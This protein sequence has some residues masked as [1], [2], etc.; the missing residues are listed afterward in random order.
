[1]KHLL[2]FLAIALA[3]VAFAN[4][5]WSANIKAADVGD[6]INEGESCIA[7]DGNYVYC[8]SNCAERASYGVIP[9]GRSTDGGATWTTTWWHDPT[10]PNQW[11][12][13][14]VIIRD[15]TGYVHLFVQYSTTVIRHY[16]STDH[17]VS[18]A[19]T[20]D[21]S[22]MTG[23]T[24]DKCWFCCHGNNIYGCWQE[25]GGAVDG[26]RFTKS[27]DGGLTWNTIVADDQDTGMSYVTTSPSG[28]V[29]LMNRNWGGSSVLCT[30]STDE[31]ET[32]APWVEIDDN[33]TYSS[34]YGDRAPNPSIAAPTDSD[35]IIT[36]VD[37]RFGNWDVLYSRSTD[38]GSTWT[39]TAQLPD[40]TAGGQC[41]GWVTA[42]PYG[43]LHAMWYHTPSWPTSSSSRWSVRYRHSEDFG[44]TWSP[45]TRLSDTTFQSPVDFMGEYH[46]M[47]ADSEHLR[48]VWTDGREGD[49]SL[50]F[51]QADLSL[52]GIAENPWNVN[53][54]A[55]VSLDVASVAGAS[56]L[57]IHFALR[58]QSA[59][60]IEAFDAAGRRLALRDLGTLAAGRHETELDGL[61]TGQAVFI[62]LTTDDASATA[63]TNLI[64]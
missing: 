9:Y 7:S 21:V 3:G 18:W 47:V 19:D 46:V 14:P 49:L 63:K 40:S 20:T 28:I 10:A 43:N 22:E 60:R 51:A 15:A 36:W 37:S 12:S 26:I 6:T 16:R 5:P 44:A 35:V 32:W 58:R 1:M 39:P 57:A 29:Y 30:R 64:R 54:P 34:G 42:D 33:C 61:P 27:T 25:F 31:G 11:H 17:G 24:V 2:V 45:S 48:A 38:G 23:S 55:D 13:D 4:P 52:I 56:P 8:I 53:R 50:W 59:A 41:K 62:R